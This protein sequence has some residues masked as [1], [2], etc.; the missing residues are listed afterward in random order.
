[1]RS[2]ARF[3]CPGSVS[4]VAADPATSRASVKLN[5][6][7]PAGTKISSR[8][9]RLGELTDAGLLDREA[10]DEVPPRVG[11]HAD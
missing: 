11:V 6:P 1:V 8:S 4:T 2:Y 7:S 10:C 9:T 3:S 5:T